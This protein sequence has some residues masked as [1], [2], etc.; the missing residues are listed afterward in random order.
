MRML[1]LLYEAAYEDGLALQL[2]TGQAMPQRPQTPA[3]GQG[4]AGEAAQPVPGT[5]DVC[6]RTGTGARHLLAKSDWDV[7]L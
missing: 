4:W 6:H 5:R 7:I 2:W 3:P 1:T